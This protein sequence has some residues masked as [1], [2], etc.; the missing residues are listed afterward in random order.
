M[1][2]RE[3]ERCLF[4]GTTGATKFVFDRC[5]DCYIQAPQTI[6]DVWCAM[7]GSKPKVRRRKF[8][9]FELYSVDEYKNESF[10]H[11]SEEGHIGLRAFLKNIA[12]INS[13]C[14]K[15]TINI[16]QQKFYLKVP[17][18]ENDLNRNAVINR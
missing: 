4:T 9:L 5:I 7:F 15:M 18:K 1:V 10:V 8:I 16:L 2:C 6:I 12:M 14:H 13:R 3:P 11:L 17:R